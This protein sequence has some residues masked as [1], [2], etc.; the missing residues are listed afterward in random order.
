MKINI[1]IEKSDD[2]VFLRKLV[3]ILPN[4]YH[5]IFFRAFEIYIEKN[6]DEIIRTIWYKDIAKRVGGVWT[7]QGRKGIYYKLLL[8]NKTYYIFRNRRM[9]SKKSPNYVV[10]EKDGDILYSRV[11][12]KRNKNLSNIIVYK[13]KEKR[14]ENKNRN[15]EM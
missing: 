13:K 12:R 10:Y 9:I 3:D 6:N 15:R 2:M 7:K 1:E 4:G 8:K 11:K 5:I 14:N